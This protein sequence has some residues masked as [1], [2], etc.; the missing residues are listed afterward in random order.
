MRQQYIKDGDNKPFAIVEDER[1]DQNTQNPDHAK[2]LH[3]YEGLLDKLSQETENT[4]KKK[5]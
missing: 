4:F 5:R 1:N 3:R 2:N